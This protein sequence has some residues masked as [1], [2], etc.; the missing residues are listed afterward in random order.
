M[1]KSQTDL[2]N[3]SHFLTIISEK[4]LGQLLI[5]EIFPDQRELLE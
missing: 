3:H 4:T 1:G 2:I 5:R